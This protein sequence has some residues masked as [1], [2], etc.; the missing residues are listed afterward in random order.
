MTASDRHVNVYNVGRQAHDAVG[1]RLRGYG[2]GSADRSGAAVPDPSSYVPYTQS[3]RSVVLPSQAP[4]VYV[5]PQTGQQV[6]YGQHAPQYVPPATSVPSEQPRKKKRGP[7]FWF[8]L[9]LALAAVVAAAVLVFLFF[10]A[11]GKSARQGTA[12]QLEGKT[13]AE[14]QAEL[15]RVVDDG[16]FNISIASTVQFPDGRSP[17]ELRIENVPGNRY[18]M[19]VVI[20]ED[21]TGQQIYETDLI[22]PNYHIQADT[23]DVPLAAGN[24]ECTA[25]FY[26]YDPE[27]EDVIG[28]AAAEIAVIVEK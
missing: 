9:L 15:D 19:R 12:G 11:D 13:E 1:G 3:D 27:S 5:Q 28:Q 10:T 24:Y 7:L 25:M 20:V 14:I 17:G 4:C 8:L 23:L 16:M 18:L 21:A 22:E 2:M 6:Y 26:A